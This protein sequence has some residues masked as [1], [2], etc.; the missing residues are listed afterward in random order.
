MAPVIL[1]LRVLER[2]AIALRSGSV[3]VAGA[4]SSCDFE[5]VFDACGTHAE[6]LDG[7]AEILLR[8]GR[9][10]EVEDVFD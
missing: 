9:G 8:T 3:E 4:I 6:G 5:C 1:G 7:Q 2:V 10:S